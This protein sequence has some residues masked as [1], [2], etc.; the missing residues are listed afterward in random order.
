MQKYCARKLP[1]PKTMSNKTL[2]FIHAI[3]FVL[4]VVV[5]L[6]APFRYNGVEQV[7]VFFP[8]FH[9]LVYA[10]ATNHLFILVCIFLLLAF[11]WIGHF[12]LVK[13]ITTT[14]YYNK[15]NIGLAVVALLLSFAAGEAVLRLMG[16]KPGVHTKQ[17]SWFN[18]VDS[19]IYLKGFATDSLGIYKI[20]TSAAT[21]ISDLVQRYNSPRINTTD[22]IYLSNPIDNGINADLYSMGLDYLCLKHLN[23]KSEFA[24]FVKETET[25]STLDQFD[26]SVL[27]YTTHPINSEGFRSVEFANHKTKKKKVLL[28]GDS[29]VYGNGSSNHTNSFADLLLTKNLAVYNASISGTDPEQYRAVAQKYIAIIKPDFVVVHLSVTSDM[30]YFEREVKPYTPVCYNTNAGNLLSCP[31]GIYFNTPFEAYNFVLDWCRIPAEIN[32]FNRFCA[33][34][35]TFTLI[36]KLLDKRGWVIRNSAR[37]DAYENATARLKEKAPVC[38]RIV[39]DIKK[40]AIENGSS[41]IYV[42]IP[43]YTANGF[44]YAQQYAG[45]ADTIAHYIP[46]IKESY[47]TEYGGHFNDTGHAWYANY[48]SQIIAEQ[49]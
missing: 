26:S 18:E 32:L 15:K 24:G 3:A 11:V 35:C 38:Q 12:G 22:S 1:K 8:R 40:T 2:L 44:H 20:D 10:I 7:Q 14:L 21:Y 4:I 25:K 29:F 36:W 6:V 42:Q 45:F 48:L 34:T 19:L 9:V 16:F 46:P 41:F 33:A 27:F 49:R 13:K 31:G 17:V 5:L 28:L 47:Y 37:L 23:Y 39:S 43:E 30:A